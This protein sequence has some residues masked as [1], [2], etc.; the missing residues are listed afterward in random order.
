M[1][2]RAKARTPDTR[3]RILAAACDEFGARGFA[4][5][6][7][8]RIAERARVNKAMIYYHFPNKRALY[9]CIIRDVFAPIIT[10]VRAAI[11]QDAAPDSKLANVIDTLVRSV[12]ESTYFLPIFLREIAD[13]AVHLGPEELA[14]IAGMFATVSGI[15]RDGL[16]QN[17]F[18][19]VHP[20]LAHF[21]LIGPLIMFRATAPVRARIKNV[22]HVEIPDADSDTMVRHLQMV[23]HRMLALPD[24]RAENELR[25]TSK[26][27]RAESKELR[28][29]TESRGEK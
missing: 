15:I 1:I 10:R 5:T 2:T 9:T 24:A 3:K 13:G 6:T 23:A 17:V 26:R 21:T 16:K 14:L 19:P 18:Q 8:D 22:R 7:V 20:A 27:Q 29:K 11:A 12:D 28:A 4:A 25:G